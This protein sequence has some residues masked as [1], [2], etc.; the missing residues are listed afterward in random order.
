M[1]T[2]QERRA[3][4]SN[5]NAV[6]VSRIASHLIGQNH[7]ALRQTSRYARDSTRP[8]PS[9][10]SDTFDP[11]TRYT[12]LSITPAA[13]LAAST[14]LLTPLPLAAIIDVAKTAMRWSISTGRASIIKVQP[15]DDPHDFTEL[16][17]FSGRTT[18]GLRR[19]FQYIKLTRGAASIQLVYRPATAGSGYPTV[20]FIF[21]G[22][23]GR[24]GV[25]RTLLLL[26][27]ADEALPRPTVHAYSSVYATVLF[28]GRA[29]GQRTE[30]LQ[31]IRTRFPRAVL[32]SS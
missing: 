28:T 1:S 21:N 12:I 5:L 31:A 27:I 15:T 6:A 11:N 3:Q 29:T 2:T 26:G 13:H 22:N 18:S 17:F 14:T 24:H 25:K 16:K 23:H 8:M 30:I 20:K 32:A 4:F 9:L 10:V 7:R 19:D